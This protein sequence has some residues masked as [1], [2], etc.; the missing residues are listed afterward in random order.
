MESVT[1]EMP[2]SCSETTLQMNGTEEAISCASGI[3]DTDFESEE[4]YGGST[5]QQSS[6]NKRI[7][8]S[9]FNTISKLVN[10]TA[11]VPE[12]QDFKIVK[13]ISRGAFGKVFLGYKKSNPDQIYAIKVMKKNDM[14]HKNMASQVVIERNAL[15]LTHSPYCVQLF[16]SLQSVSSIYLVME[17]MV[18]GDLK[19]LL[20]FYGY[21]EESMAAFYTAEVT[22]ALEY[23]HSHGIVHRDLKPDNMLLSREGHVKL[24][25]FGLSKISRLHR[26]LE[27]SDLVNC[28]PSLCTRTPGQLLSLTS[29]LSFGSGQKSNDSS[30]S[31][32]L[33]SSSRSNPAVNLLPVLQQSS[34]TVPSPN[35]TVSSVGTSGDYSRVSGITPFQSADD[36]SF[37]KNADKESRKKIQQM[38]NISANSTNCSFHTCEVSPEVSR[39][40]N[41][42]G[43]EDEST[44][45]AENSQHP[46]AACMSPPSNLTNSF[47]RGTKR[48]RT[49][50]SG[51]TGLTREIYLMELDGDL[52]PKRKNR[53]TMFSC[54]SPVP[55]S[56]GTRTRK[57][58]A[59]E[60]NGTTQDNGS[61]GRVAFST[62]VSS[63]KQ[64]KEDDNLST[65][66]ERR[67]RRSEDDKPI[68]IK[69]TR[70]NLSPP[71]ISYSAPDLQLDSIH[72]H[73]SPPGISPI[74]TP[75]AS[76][77]SYTPFR[78]PKS[79][80]RG[81][82][83]GIQHSE[84][85]ILGT[86][87]YLAPELLLRQ[88][89][90]PAVD[91]WALGVCL[92]EFCTGVPP[93]NDD[94]PQAVFANILARD[95][96]WPEG[97]EALSKSAVEAIDVLLTLDQSIRPSAKDVRTMSLFKNFPWE[98]P[99]KATPPFVPQPDDNYDTYYFQ[100]RNILQHLNV[101]NCDT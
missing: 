27:I 5:P 86:P 22:L 38:D 64:K 9:I 7:D 46:V 55:M 52:T 72:E 20:G 49:A 85:K 14:I 32:Q 33:D 23:L 90:G 53:G 21:M 3:N 95:V 40:T 92:F 4:P 84:E 62:P 74:K 16:Y 43:E 42:T 87:D 70:F 76:I 29:H 71:C 8:N 68:S 61:G 77:G 11:K 34:K 88:G 41:K 99:Q 48:K 44:L 12:I 45:E 36:L 65:S 67:R 101:S 56:M 91:W 1:V 81:T 31:N 18:G 96:P 50:A 93:F 69:S 54:R 58:K 37:C 26:D 57:D 30:Q 47:S 19:S 35:S 82:Q 78:T 63:L 100:A 89:H 28:T 94:T 83:G 79:V 13:P 15:A 97:E 66:L 10:R 80:R 98:E 51:S 75:A 17:Y 6:E 24:T 2:A 59:V 60:T 73:R 25:D 39:S